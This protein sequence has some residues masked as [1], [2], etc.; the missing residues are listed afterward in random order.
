[1]FREVSGNVFALSNTPRAEMLSWHTHVRKVN[2]SV[3]EQNK[4][5]KITC[6]TSYYIINTLWFLSL[7]LLLS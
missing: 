3:R 7:L 2:K 6:F 1:M 4:S 5:N